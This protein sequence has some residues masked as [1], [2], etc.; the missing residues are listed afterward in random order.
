MASGT[1]RAIASILVVEDDEAIAE[2]LVD[3][4]DSEGYRA[5]VAT[6]GA[7]ALSA[8]RSERVALMLLDLGLP[9]MNGRQMREQ[10]LADEAIAGIPA[11]ILTASAVTVPVDNLPLIRKP[12]DCDHLLRVIRK[13]LEIAEA[14]R[15]RGLIEAVSDVRRQLEKTMEDLQ[16]IRRA[17]GDGP[18][19]TR[20]R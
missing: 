1:R 7:S 18:P 8:L 11:I 19:S 5:I 9:D 10:Q 16:A 2:A 14:A 12:F 6:D 13:E 20:R 17:S 15:H 3:L 4:L